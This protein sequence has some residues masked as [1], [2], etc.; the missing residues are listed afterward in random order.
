MRFLN[1]GFLN[2][3]FSILLRFRRDNCEF[4]FTFCEPYHE[5]C[6][7]AVYHTLYKKV[8]TFHVGMYHIPKSVH[9]PDII[10]CTVLT[11]RV[12]Y[13]VQNSAHLPCT[14]S[15]KVLTFRV[16]YP[17]KYSLSVYHFPKNAHFP[18]TRYYPVQC[19]LSVYHTL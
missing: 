12:P 17:I 11:F 18:C 10:P 3:H 2:F 15:L 4:G 14:I 5:K 19:S 13:P 16:P 8:L 7:P 1:S 9:I 6:S